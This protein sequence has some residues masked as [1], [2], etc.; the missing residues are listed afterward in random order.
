LSDIVSSVILFFF[1]TAFFI[2]IT[3]LMAKYRREILEWVT[4][5]PSQDR[6]MEDFDTL[7]DMGIEEKDA[8]DRV[9]HYRIH[10]REIKAAIS[11]DG[12]E[13][14]KTE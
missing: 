1:F 5:P 13:A 4:K 8:I 6:E 12:D 10:R 9:R 14:I 3:L 2:F 11:K 7:T